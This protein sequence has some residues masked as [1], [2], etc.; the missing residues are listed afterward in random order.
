M[1]IPIV[2]VS[3]GARVRVKRG[4]LPSDPAF[5]GR[6]GTVV[7]ATEYQTNMYGVVLDG[8]RETR[9]FSPSELEVVEAEALPPER[10][11]AKQRRALP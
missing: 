2:L 4:V 7:E 5:I 3:S 8:E 10:Q 6:T 11:E 9:M 1:A